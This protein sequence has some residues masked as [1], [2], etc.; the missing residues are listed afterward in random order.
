MKKNL[1]INKYGSSHYPSSPILLRANAYNDKYF[2]VSLL[3]E[4]IVY[5]NLGRKEMKS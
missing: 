4:S 2:L 5:R 3:K 1:E